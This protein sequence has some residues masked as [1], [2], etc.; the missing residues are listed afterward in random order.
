M[1]KVKIVKDRGSIGMK[2]QCEHK[3]I[4]GYSFRAPGIF[5]RSVPC[6]DCG[7]PIKLIPIWRIAYAIVFFAAFYIGVEL[8]TVLTNYLMLMNNFLNVI[9]E[10]MVLIIFLWI[11]NLIQ[12]LILRFGK[13]IQA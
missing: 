8:G 11:A 10:V 1:F 4:M 13:W 3:Y 12:S 9:I 7:T 5:F 2:G 6:D